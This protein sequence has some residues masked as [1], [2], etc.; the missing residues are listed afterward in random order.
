ML[1]IEQIQI[2]AQLADNAEVMIEKLEKS[3]EKNDAEDFMNSQGEILDI[4]KKISDILK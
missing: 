1:D 4:Q 3:Y 2:L